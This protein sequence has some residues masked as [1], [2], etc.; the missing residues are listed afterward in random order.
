MDSIANI[1][2]ILSGGSWL[3][4]VVMVWVGL[5]ASINPCMGA[6]VPL[7]LGNKREP[8]PQNLLLFVTGFC[9]TLMLLGLT[10]ARL[11]QALV[12]PAKA[13]LIMLSFL[14][15]LFG[16]MLLNVKPPFKISGFYT[17]RNRR[18][19]PIIK[20]EGLKQ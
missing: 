17:V 7:V 2:T 13:W 10:A 20:K 19:R 5:A 11:G 1:N 15:L 18:L 16:L 12:L 3:T 9:T 6:M 8:K 14:Y 4:L